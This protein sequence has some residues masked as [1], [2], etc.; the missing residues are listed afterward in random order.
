M[1]LSCRGEIHNY[2]FL[3][4]FLTHYV[5]DVGVAGSNPV[6]P[7]SVPGSVPAA[8]ARS[9]QV[10]PRSSGVSA[11]AHAMERSAAYL[12][13]MRSVPKPRLSMFAR[14]FRVQQILE[15]GIPVLDV[16]LVRPAPA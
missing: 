7:R 3:L 15:L 2:M 1:V 10:G 4:Y 5:R 13:D 16:P 11:P 14:S 12:N 8:F 9:F 6:T